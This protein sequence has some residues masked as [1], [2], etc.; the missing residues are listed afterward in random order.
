MK[1]IHSLFLLLLCALFA[2]SSFA[3]QTNKQTQP[4]TLKEGMRKKLAAITSAERNFFPAKKTRSASR[5][6]AATYRNYDGAAFLVSDSMTYS[7]NSNYGYDPTFET[8][9][10]DFTNTYL[11]YNQNNLYDLSLHYSEVGGPLVLTD[12][13]V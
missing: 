12:S 6:I 13:T 1:S 3:Q 8:F 11:Y 9:D 2:E 10:T 5:L 7:Y 4:A